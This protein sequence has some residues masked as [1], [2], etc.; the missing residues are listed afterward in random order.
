MSWAQLGGISQNRVRWRELCLRPYARQGV[1]MNDND[2]DGYWLVPANTTVRNEQ[3]YSVG[4][5]FCDTRANVTLQPNGDLTPCDKYACV[6]HSINVGNNTD[7]TSLPRYKSCKDITDKTSPRM[8]IRLLNGLVVMCD[9]ESDGGGWIIL[10]RRITGAL[11]FYRTWAEFKNGFGDYELGEF[12]L[13]NENIHCLTNVTRYDMRVDVKYNGQNYTFN[14]ADFKV[15]SE[16]NCYKLRISSAS[17]VIYFA[18]SNAN[19]TTYDNDHDPFPTGNAAKIWKTA[20]WMC[21]SCKDGF[22]L[23]LNGAWSGTGSYGIL[24][25]SLSNTTSVSFGEMKIREV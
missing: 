7:S 19:F 15:E 2:E 4:G 1:H 8:L 20:G 24:A 17:P 12:Y 10:Q 3:I 11:D 5:N 23:N 22:M 14:F 9:T 16:L 21:F 13:G 18:H 25:R 6:G